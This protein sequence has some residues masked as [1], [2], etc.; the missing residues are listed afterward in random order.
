MGIVDKTESIL[1]VVSRQLYHTSRSLMPDKN[2]R[3]GQ[4]ALGNLERLRES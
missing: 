3:D 2:G 4:I 1:S